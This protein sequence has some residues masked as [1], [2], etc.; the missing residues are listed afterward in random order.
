MTTTNIVL[1]DC[2]CPFQIIHCCC[3]SSC[4][5]GCANVKSTAG[6]NSTP[7]KNR[8]SKT[9]VLHPY[10]T[11]APMALCPTP[12]SLV[13][14]GRD[15]PSS[16]NGWL[17]RGTRP[18]SQPQNLHFLLPPRKNQTQTLDIAI[19]PLIHACAAAMLPHDPLLE[20]V[21]PSR[22]TRPQRRLA[23]TSSLARKPLSHKSLSVRWCDIR[24]PQPSSATPRALVHRRAMAPDTRE[25]CGAPPSLLH[26]WRRR[27]GRDDTSAPRP[28]PFP[29]SIQEAFFQFQHP[30][31]FRPLFSALNDV[32]Q[33]RETRPARLSHAGARGPFRSPARRPALRPPAS[34]RAC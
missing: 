3:A 19:Y 30:R 22:A 32:L 15:T 12:F 33:H 28:L 25:H 2:H 17:T 11:T 9:S 23:A 27:R 5:R 6:D 26:D 24:K 34:G 20:A 7:L 21:P 16:R 18:S 29:T 10:P 13:R 14:P 31:F 8:Q 4:R 1:V